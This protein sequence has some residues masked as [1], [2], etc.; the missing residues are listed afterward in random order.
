[1]EKKLGAFLCV[2]AAVLGSKIKFSC[3]KAEAQDLERRL[4]A[5]NCQITIPINNINNIREI[6]SLCKH[7]NWTNS[8]SNLKSMAS[9]IESV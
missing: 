4:I 5:I 1:M 6:N 8:H 7:Q 9:V 2:L 3:L